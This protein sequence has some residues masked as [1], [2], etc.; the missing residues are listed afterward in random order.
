MAK[1]RL[2]VCGIAFL[3]TAGVCLA[4]APFGSGGENMP[5]T[6]WSLTPDAAALAAEMKESGKA[7]RP[8]TDHV[9]F[10]PRAQLKYSCHETHFIHRW[11]E[12][13]LDQDSTWA[14]TAKY[15]KL[16]HPEAWR[17]TV[18]SVKLGKMDGLAVCISSARR[19]EAVEMS[20][21]PGGELPLLIELPYDYHDGGLESHIKVAETALSMPN[22]Y[23]IDGKVVLTRYPCV[24]DEGVAFCEKLRA[25]LAERF[26][27]DRFIVMFYVSPL[28]G[29]PQSGPITRETLEGMRERL[30]RYLRKMDGLFISCLQMYNPRRYGEDFERDVLVPL[31]R[32][33]MAEPEFAG[34]KYLGLNVHPGHENCYRWS[35]SLDSQGTRLLCDRLKTMLA[36]RPDFIIGCEWDEQNENTHFRPTVFNGY[37]HQRIVRHFADVSAGRAPE[38]F[39]GDDTSVPNLV[40]SYRKSLVAG[41]PVEVEVRN[42]PDGTFKDERFKVGFAWRNLKGETVK[43]YPSQMLDADGLDAV[44]FVTPAT[45]LAAENRLLLPELTVETSDGRRFNFGEGFWALDLNALRAV[46]T[47]WVKQ[48]LRER[49]RGVSGALTVGTEDADGTRV[50]AG[51]FSSPVP[52]KSVEV[53]EGPDTIYMYD[54]AATDDVNRIVIRLSVKALPVATKRFPL[55]GGIRFEGSPGVRIITKKAWHVDSISDGWR[56]QNTRYGYQTINLFASLPR[57]EADSAVIAVNLPQVFQTRIAVKDILRKGSLGLPG[58]FGGNLVACRYLSQIG[59]PPPCKVREGEFRFRMEPAE[60]G[61]VLRMQM[62][63]MDGRVWRG[64]PNT[65]FAPSGR[66]RTIHVFE[67]DEGRVTEFTVDEGRLDEPS[68]DFDPSRGSVVWSGL[69][70][71]FCGLLGGAATLVSGIGGGESIYGDTIA[72]YVKGNEQG[73]D[74]CAPEAVTEPNGRRTLVFKGGDYVMLPQQ[75]VSKFAGFDIELD[76]KPADLIGVQTLVDGG[77]AAYGIRLK[78]GI[79]EGFIFSTDN[80]RLQRGGSAIRVRGPKLRMGEWNHVKMSYDERVL[81][82]SVDGVSGTPAKASCCQMQSRYTALGAANH[83]LDF[84]RGAMSGL[85]FRAR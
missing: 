63:D 10:F 24:K 75:L 12:R 16:L 25:R 56:F 1:T 85:K 81:S 36:L 46:D 78:G 26:G 2:D 42:I 70:R 73:I 18:E 23:R 71:N 41:E 58:P 20:R 35:Y 45:E 14:A 29:V 49:P 57:E 31:Y 82:V 76:V 52:L 38:P 5:C 15:G 33:V 59:I 39:P 6:F 67:R 55:V 53:L 48:A 37:V 44:W 68:Y 60:R 64:A 17:K 62:V 11:W 27:P 77:N 61:G 65:F 50:V 4:D 28:D 83:S 30:R 79:P 8:R 9:G 19:D 34:R 47:K 80:Y 21:I 54:P 74:W 69:G 72:R 51:R 43:S 13:P 22:A 32:S 66:K 40:L 84:F 3:L 7:Y